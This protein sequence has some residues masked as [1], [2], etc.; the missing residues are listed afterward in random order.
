MENKDLD[1]V[2]DNILCV[3]P[4]IN[5]KLMKPIFQ[6]VKQ[7]IPLYHFQVLNFLMEQ[8]SA[9]VS[10]ISNILCVSRPNTTPLID[11]LIE[12]ELVQRSSNSKDRRITNISITEKGRITAINNLQLLKGKLKLKISSLN[13]EDISDLINSF[14]NIRSILN[15]ISPNS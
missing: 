2:I 5:K 10:E 3:F 12:E 8:E 1:L 11:K 6:M 13:K 4:L 7:E 15:K 9:T 14:D